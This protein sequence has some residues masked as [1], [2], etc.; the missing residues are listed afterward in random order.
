MITDFEYFA[1]KT[2]KEALSLLNQ[3]RDDC[4]VIAGGQSMLVLMRQGLVS[5]EYIIDIKGVSEMD[6]IRSEAGGG[7][8]IG[9]LTTH[10]SIEKSSVINMNVGFAFVITGIKK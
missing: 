8:N 5:P 9:A 10:R 4:K 1:P 6:Y 3:Y 7:L 2:L